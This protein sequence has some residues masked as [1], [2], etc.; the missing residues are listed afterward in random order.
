M[1]LPAVAGESEKMENK[2]LGKKIPTVDDLFESM[3]TWQLGGVLRLLYDEDKDERTNGELIDETI[4]DLLDE[5]KENKDVYSGDISE[6]IHEW[7]DCYSE[8][9]TAEAFKWYSGDAGLEEYANA[10][11]DEYGFDK[12]KGIVG[13]LQGGMYLLLREFAKLVLR[14]AGIE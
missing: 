7:A 3:Y 9:Y 6:F 8:V 5:W 2:T 11:I 13:V 14:E 1:G 10:F 12:E 4:R